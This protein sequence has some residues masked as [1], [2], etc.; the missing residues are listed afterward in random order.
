MN[1]SSFDEIA[2][3]FLAR[4][5]RVVWCSVATIDSKG[6]PRSR[7]LHPYWEGS[8][9][10][11]ATYRASHKAKHLEANPHVSLAYVSEVFKPVYVDAT[12]AWDEDPASKQHVWDLFKSAAE[13]MGYDPAP[14]FGS[15]DHTGF[16]V[17]KLTPWRIE[18]SSFPAQKPE[19]VKVWHADAS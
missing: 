7:I 13:P 9:G 6:R 11:I 15:V 18:I 3:E 1:V 14:I 2:E 17:L 19:D 10:W 8:T 5:F 16:G 12:A 4:T